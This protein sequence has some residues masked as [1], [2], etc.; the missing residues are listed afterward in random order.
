MD[1]FFFSFSFFFFLNSAIKKWASPSWTVHYVTLSVDFC[2]SHHL[3]SDPLC[4]PQG[5]WNLQLGCPK[6]SLGEPRH[7]RERLLDKD[8]KL[9]V[10]FCLFGQTHSM[11]KFLGQGSIE[12]HSGDLR[13]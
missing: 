8:R 3:C 13:C 6:P 2:T 10:F 7:L 11:W 1:F 4:P 9:V 12:S 5:K